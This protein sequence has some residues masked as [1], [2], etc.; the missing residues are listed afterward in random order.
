MPCLDAT[1]LLFFLA[2][3]IGH[4]CEPYLVLAA[5]GTLGWAL[6]VWAVHP[7]IITPRT[8]SNTKAKGGAGGVDRSAQQATSAG[9]V[10]VAHVDGG[11]GR[12]AVGGA[13]RG[14]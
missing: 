5:V 14:L 9:R 7:P 6:L 3:M 11:V 8:V 12:D 2:S 10:R 13:G 1:C 4:A